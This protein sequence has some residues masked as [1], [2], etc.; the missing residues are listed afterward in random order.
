M[1]T[2]LSSL[3]LGLRPD[4]AAFVIGS[5]QLFREMVEAGWIKPVVRRHKITL[6]DRAQLAHAWVR[7]LSGEVPNAAPAEEIAQLTT[8]G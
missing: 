5:E 3:K 1:K 7:V 8:G 6:C 2:D 4:E